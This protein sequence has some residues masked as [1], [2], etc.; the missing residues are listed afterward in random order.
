MSRTLLLGGLLLLAA[1]D[2]WH[3]SIN[4]DGLVFISIVDDRNELRDRFRVRIRDVSGTTR[5]LEVPSSGELSLS[6]TSDGALQLTLM[7]PE[8]CLVAGSNPRTVTVSAGE[9]IRVAF[10][11]HCA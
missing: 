9:E 2:E 11:V 3:L 5:M 1:C 7:T 10:E 4:S 8:G 6:P